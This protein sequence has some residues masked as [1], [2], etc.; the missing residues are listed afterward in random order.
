[1]PSVSPH[2]KF[3]TKD[4][5]AVEATIEEVSLE[6]SSRREDGFSRIEDCPLCYSPMVGRTES[7]IP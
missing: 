2:Q 6:I 7:R 5:S 4:E 3:L 1:M